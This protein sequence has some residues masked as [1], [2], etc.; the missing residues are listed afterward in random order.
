MDN[1]RKIFLIR[2]CR[3][4]LPENISVYLGIKDIPLSNEGIKEAEELK[5]YF[6]NISLNRIYSSPL[7]RATQTAEIIADKKTNVIIKDGFSEFNIGKWDGMTFAEIKEEFPIEYEERGKDLEN[8]IV[9]GGESMSACRSRAMKELYATL[10]ETSGN[11]LIVAHAGVNRAIISKVLG[12]GIKDSYDFKQ[13]YGSINVL[14]FNSKILNVL[15]IGANVLD[16][17]KMG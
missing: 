10:H 17:N 14:T 4:Q 12:I 8:Y 3:P 9:E 7:I 2:H 1:I 13:E 6:L 11:I 5:K 16:G 15:E